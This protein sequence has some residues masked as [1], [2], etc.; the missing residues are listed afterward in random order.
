MSKDK[1]IFRRE[2]G[3]GGGWNATVET[4]GFDEIIITY[5]HAE[6]GGPYDLAEA[7]VEHGMLADVI[8]D[9]N[10]AKSA[11]A[12]KLHLSRSTIYRWIRGAT[13]P[14]SE[15]HKALLRDWLLGEEG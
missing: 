1:S 13:A 9:R 11:L 14:Q 15:V 8:E 3:I 2:Y 10:I 4:H 6:K 7:V 5:A 12:K